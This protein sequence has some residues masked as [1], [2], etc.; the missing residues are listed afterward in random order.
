MNALAMKGGD[1]RVCK[2]FVNRSLEMNPNNHSSG[3]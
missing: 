3:E 1:E 2:R